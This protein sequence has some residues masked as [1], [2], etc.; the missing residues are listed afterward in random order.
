MAKG[1]TNNPNGR[2]RGKPNK[3]TTEMK[4]WIQQLIDGN[5]KQLE[6][7]LQMLEPKDRWQIIERLMQYTIPKMQSVEAKV[8]LDK[9]S[10]EQLNYVVEKM[11]NETEK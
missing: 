9:L 6:D 8:E 2:P 10:E 4:T 5:R 11:L 3:V 7:D 1:K